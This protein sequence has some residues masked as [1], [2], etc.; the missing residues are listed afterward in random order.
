MVNRGWGTDRRLFRLADSSV[1][2][3]QK[4]LFEMTQ[5]GWLG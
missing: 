3:Q 2:N 5:L 1:N 4:F